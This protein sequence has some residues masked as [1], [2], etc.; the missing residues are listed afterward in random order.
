[1][2]VPNAPLS[3]IPALCSAN[4][5]IAGL[6]IR[7]HEPCDWR[8]IAEL[9]DLPKVR[10]GT[11]GLPFTSK[12]Q[13]RISLETPPDGLTGVVA[14][15]DARIVGHASITRHKGRRSHAGYIVMSVHD[16]FS[17]RGIGTAL[18][19]ALIHL[20]DN[21]LNLKRLELTVFVDNES[22]IRLYNKF[23]FETEGKHRADAFR[24]GQ[25]VDSFAMARLKPGWRHADA[26]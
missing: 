13:W 24:D 1:M 12:E 20:S 19:T 6:A 26:E 3:T 16:D 8:Q 22:A 10:W 21:W 9:M 2:G 25:Y 18:M 15:L 17:R 5:G 14:E 4:S 7:S 23:G 11:L